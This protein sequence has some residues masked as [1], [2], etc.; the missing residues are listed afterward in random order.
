MRFAVVV[1]PGSTCD[2]DCYEAIETLGQ[3]VSYVWHTATDLSGYGCVVLPGGFSYGDYLRP[4]AI[5]RTSPVMDAVRRAAEAGARVL[6][7]CNGFQILLEA[8]M[9]PGALLRNDSL[10]FRSETVTLRV[11]NARTPFTHRYAA[12]QEIEVP[13]AHADGNYYCDPADLARLQREER[14]VMRYAGP[15]PNGSLD[16]IAG[17]CNEAGN[18][19]GLMPHP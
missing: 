12:G 4:G 19:L 10:K 6:G 11:D 13:I 3:P 17:I 15:N 9:L 5:A 2:E 8:R 18:V 1:F 7:I 14:V 16:A